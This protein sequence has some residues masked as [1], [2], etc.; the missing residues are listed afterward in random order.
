MLLCYLWRYLMARAPK[1]INYMRPRG[2]R[3]SCAMRQ[4]SHSGD[5]PNAGPAPD[6]L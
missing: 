6:P 5:A 2:A 3:I 1:N 4:P